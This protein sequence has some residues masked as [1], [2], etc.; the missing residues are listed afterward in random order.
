MLRELNTVGIP[1]ADMLRRKRIN[2]LRRKRVEHKGEGDG[3]EAG[4]GES[5]SVVDRLREWEEKR[6]L[7]VLQR[8]QRQ[9]EAEDEE[10]Q[11]A[12]ASSF[13]GK[14][15]G[16]RLLRLGSAAGGS[17]GGGAEG[18]LDQAGEAAEG[19]LRQRRKTQLS[20]GETEALLQ[21]MNAD[22]QKRAERNREHDDRI[23]EG[24]QKLLQY[25]NQHVA[26]MPPRPRVDK[27]KPRPGS[28]AARTSC[29]KA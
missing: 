5:K 24:M 18:E 19:G 29:R 6:K 26:G 14:S 9:R 21:R 12:R 8:L 23:R 4:E 15:V 7:K 1:S 10:L 16:S 17:G 13:G 20:S 3:S 22:A 27:R 2:G 28:A 11:L 25:T